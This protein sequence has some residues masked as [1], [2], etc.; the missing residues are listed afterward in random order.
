MKEAAQ[1]FGTKGFF[2]DYDARPDEPLKQAVGKA[3][4]DGF[5]KLL[6]GRLDPNALARVVAEATAAGGEEMNAAEFV[7]FL[8][9]ASNAKQKKSGSITRGDAMQLMWQLLNQK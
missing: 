9:A 1:Y 7:A 2:H 4:A 3:W 6:N 5:H 8:P